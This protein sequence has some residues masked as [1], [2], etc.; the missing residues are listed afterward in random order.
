MPCMVSASVTVRPRKPSESRSS[1]RMISGAAWR[2]CCRRRSPAARCAP[3]SPPPLRPR[4][5]RGRARAPRAAA[6]PC[7]RPPPAATG[8]S[9]CRCRRAP[10]SASAWRRRRW[11]AG[12]ARTTAARR[13]T[14]CG[15]SPNERTLMTGLAGLTFTS[16]T[17]ANTSRTPRCQR[18]ATGDLA[19]A[20]RQRGVAGGAD[21]HVARQHRR[22]AAA[23]QRREE[24]AALEAA[25]GRARG[26]R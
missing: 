18:L 25:R 14:A 22:A 12:R 19:G 15:S 24:G 2:A 11:T 1:P 5:R 6:A 16:T 4:C 26:R 20:A 10:E 7:R 9:R 23:A 17:G 21:G 13:A 3:S 8:A